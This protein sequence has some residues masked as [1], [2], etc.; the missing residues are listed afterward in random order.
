MNHIT[1]AELSS[2]RIIKSM[3]VEAENRKV[4]AEKTA[5]TIRHQL[6]EEKN[7]KV[8]SKQ[9]IHILELR[10]SLAKEERRNAQR[11]IAEIKQREQS[12]TLVSPDTKEIC[13]ILFELVGL[14]SKKFSEGVLDGSEEELQHCMSRAKIALG[15]SHA[16]SNGR[17]LKRKE[18]PVDTLKIL[19]SIGARL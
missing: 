19:D 15:R 14:V 1:P 13:A 8:P 9:A 17:E 12:L 2:E 16:Y 3:L 6:A 10:L 5:E 18:A 11:F 7:A 4:L